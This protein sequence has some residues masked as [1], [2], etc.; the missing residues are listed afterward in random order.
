MVG[1]TVKK[2]LGHYSYDPSKPEGQQYTLRWPDD[3]V[4]Q[5]PE[6]R[7]EGKEDVIYLDDFVKQ[8]IAA[9]EEQKDGFW[10]HF[11][12]G[13]LYELEHPIQ[14]A[15]EEW[16]GIFGNKIEADKYNEKLKEYKDK[17]W[18]NVLKGPNLIN[19]AEDKTF[20]DEKGNPI[21]LEGLVAAQLDNPYTRDII[22]LGLAVLT[23]LLVIKL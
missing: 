14:A 11:K 1:F 8:S 13:F 16:A 17:S 21:S 2:G 12:E 19:A 18:L 5:P 6:L 23:V 15:Q 10:N 20:T 9:E 3:Q 7:I 4:H 22:Y